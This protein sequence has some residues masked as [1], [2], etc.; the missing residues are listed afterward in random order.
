MVNTAM[1]RP[2]LLLFLTAF[3]CLPVVW[4]GEDDPK[5]TLKGHVPSEVLKKAK[6]LGLL[7]PQQYLFLTFSLP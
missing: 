3:L 1:S 5:V 7:D 6:D 4:A 2:L